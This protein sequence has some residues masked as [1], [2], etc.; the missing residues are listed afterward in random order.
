MPGICTYIASVSDW[1]AVQTLHREWQAAISS[2]V[3]AARYSLYRGSNDA[4]QML[5]VVELTYQDDVDE[6]RKEVMEHMAPVLEGGLVDEQ[7]WEPLPWDS[8]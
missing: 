7:V 4:R 1:K 2:S 8:S 5:L 3:G 6:V